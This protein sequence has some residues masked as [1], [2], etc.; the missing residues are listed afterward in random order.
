MVPICKKVLFCLFVL[1]LALAALTASLASVLRVS[2]NSPVDGPGSTWD[3]AFKTI[4]SAVTAAQ[5]G[6]EI[7]VARGTYSGLTLKD[8]VA[9]YAGFA[10]TETTRDQRNPKL[11]VTLLTGTVAGRNGV[12]SA[13]RLDGFTISVPASAL[14][15]VDCRG[16]SPTIAGNT[17]ITRG[18]TGILGYLTSA[19]ITENTLIGGGGS[20]I[21][22]LYNST[23]TITSNAVSGYSTGISYGASGVI[24][25][26]TITGNSTGLA[27]NYAQRTSLANNIIAFN[28]TGISSTS[29]TATLSH[30]CVYGNATNYSGLPQGAIDIVQDPILVAESYGDV[31]IQPNSPCVDAGDDSYVQPSSTDIDGQPRIQGSHVDIGAD[32]SDGV[33][34][35]FTPTIIH[36]SP[37]GN[38]T[39]DGLSWATAKQTVHAAI[40]TAS[41]AGGEVWVAKGTYTENLTLRPYAFLYGGFAGTETE[42]SARNWRANV[43]QIVGS[44]TAIGLYR[45][46]GL[47]GFA[48]W[49]AQGFGVY[50][51]E[52]AIDIIH[53][54]IMGSSVGVSV[55]ALCDCQISNNFVEDNDT[56]IQ[57]NGGPNVIS[58]NVVAAN[59]IGLAYSGS[60]SAVNNTIIDCETAGI[61]LTSGSP[62]IANN[63]I[64]YNKAGIQNTSASPTLGHN[65]LYGNTEGNYSGLA[66]GA[67]DLQEDPQLASYQLGRAHIQPSSPCVDAGDSA[68]VKPGWT[69]LDGQSRIMGAAVDI[70]A[71]E[72]D[73]SSWPTDPAIIHVS[74]SG[75]DDS[76]GLTWARAKKTIQAAIDAAAAAGGEVWVADGTYQQDLTLKPFCYLYGGFNGTETSRDQRI[77]RK[78]RERISHGNY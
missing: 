19:V 65:C 44:I 73:G 6:D 15:A 20:G 66:A 72:S 60:A 59:G 76:N 75:D 34:R 11:N 17:I 10:G 51:S 49:G 38:D 74:P 26:N 46:T 18:G 31:H 14:E 67:T 5:P 43:S 41:M 48:V 71:D 40:D 78:R 22:I 21:S 2:A 1:G 12:T 27:L 52:A 58:D 50:C 63:I 42:R 3:N 28:G 32:E 4:P 33:E 54:Q 30:N 29:S 9:V 24:A 68:L 69:D 23:P 70:G 57:S 37:N 55:D 53:N 64:A 47:D 77:V 62:E 25:N 16:G 56:G 61:S 8:Q 13:A 39:N 45:T 36:V 7:W 35:P